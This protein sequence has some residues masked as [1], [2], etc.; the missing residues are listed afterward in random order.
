MEKLSVFIT[1][2]NNASTLRLCLDS[3]KWASEIIIVDSFSS[4][5]TL[6]I[7]ESY[8]NCK[9]FQHQFL[10]YGAQKQLALEKT[11]H[12]WVLLLDADEALTNEAQAEIQTLLQRSPTAAGYTLPRL[13]QMFWQMCDRR[14]RLNHFLR[15]FR[16][17]CGQMGDMPVHAAPEV[18]GV[19]ER[20]Q[21][22][23]YHFGEIDIHTKVEKINNYSSGLVP[24]KVAKGCR[25]VGLTMILYPPLYFFKTYILKRNFFNGWAGFITSVTAAYYVFLKY[26]KV[27]E[28][29]QDRSEL[30][31]DVPRREHGPS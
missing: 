1:T 6:T 11:H 31:V 15:L 9:I 27:H 18:E 20:L 5:E 25:H 22:P 26:A 2:F 16:R 28:H 23:F 19:I 3:V 7:A 12:L 4:D 17:D 13:E 30:P 10:G 14:T 24:D 21:H 29:F 8:P